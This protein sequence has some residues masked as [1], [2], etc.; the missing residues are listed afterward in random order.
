MTKTDRHQEFLFRYSLLHIRGVG[1]LTANKLIEEWGSAQNLYKSDKALLKSKITHKKVL[2]AILNKYFLEE[3]NREWELMENQGIQFVLKGEE[4][5]P[6]WLQNIS[7]APLILYYIGIPNWNN[8][9]NVS[10]VGTRK[11]THYGLSVTKELVEALADFQCNIISGMAL[12]IDS[13]AHRAAIEN[14]LLTFAIMGHG[15][16]RIY[17]SKNEKL[18]QQIIKNGALLSEYSSQDT[19]RKENFL[20]RNR[21]IAAISQS[22]IIVESKFGGGAMT[23]ARHAFNYDRDLYAVPGKTTDLYSQGCNFLIKNMQAKLLLDPQEVYQWFGE[24]KPKQKELF[25]ELTDEEKELVKELEKEEKL[26]IDELAFRMNVPTF[27][28]MPLL[29]ELEFKEV[30]KA[31]P[32]KFYSL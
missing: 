28:L 10:I 23:T 2:E 25:I 18:A 9:V 16:D 30:V 26:Q 21:I 6:K 22:T 32:G 27:Q 3:A 8:K 5:Y 4:L 19:F 7:D 11:S 15:L 17:P 31:L 14:Q 24:K 12:G 13:K 29:L 1:C 20:E